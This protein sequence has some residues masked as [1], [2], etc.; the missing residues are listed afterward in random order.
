MGDQTQ[1][2]SVKSA[3]TYELRQVRGTDVIIKGAVEQFKV[4]LPAIAGLMF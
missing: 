3:E 4:S 1:F 2:A